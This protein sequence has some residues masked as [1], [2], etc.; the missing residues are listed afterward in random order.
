MVIIGIN[1]LSDH[2]LLGYLQTHIVSFLCD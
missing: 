2:W 1:D